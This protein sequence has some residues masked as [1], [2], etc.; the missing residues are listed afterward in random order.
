[1]ERA[2][3]YDGGQCDP[4]CKPLRL[5]YTHVYP[6]KALFLWLNHGVAPTSLFTK[7]EFAMKLSNGRLIRRQF[8][9]TVEQLQ[10]RLCQCGA[11]RF[12]IGAIY[13]DPPVAQS[14][15][16]APQRLRKEFVIDIDITAYDDIRTCCTGKRICRRCWGF[17]AAAINVLEASLRLQFGYKSILWVF[18]GQR[19]VHCWVSD[20]S[21]IELKDAHRHAALGWL[22]VLK[23]AKGLKTSPAIRRSADLNS[24]LHPMIRFATSKIPCNFNQLILTTQDAFAW[25]DRWRCLLGKLSGGSLFQSSLAAA[26][27]AEPERCS[28]DKW[29]DILAEAKDLPGYVS[30]PRRIGLQKSMEDMVLQCMYP[31]LDV[32]VSR[33][34]E[35]LLKAPFCVHPDTGRIC[36]PIDPSTVEEFNPDSVPTLTDILEEISTS[37]GEPGCLG[38]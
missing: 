34:S 16:S 20:D 5:Y 38:R 10:K 12:E 29:D 19:G 3:D 17:L 31:R 9:Q 7:R 30:R 1:M 8:F 2:S 26:W 14:S 23:N 24:P 36:V 28:L 18:S 15:F 33:R 13:D 35:H 6:F 21:A 27:E 32:Q 25:E 11:T 22:D 37:Q 4:A